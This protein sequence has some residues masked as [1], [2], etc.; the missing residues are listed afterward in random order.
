MLGKASEIQIAEIDMV[1]YSYWQ[2]ENKDVAIIDMQW[3]F[4]EDSTYIF[5]IYKEA[6]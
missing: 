5:I 4:N 2:D 3:R 1:D 6:E